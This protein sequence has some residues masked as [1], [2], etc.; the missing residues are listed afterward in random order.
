MTSCAIFSQQWRA[1]SIAAVT[2]ATRRRRQQHISRQPLT[3]PPG[4]RTVLR[5]S[6]QRS[7]TAVTCRHYCRPPKE[8][9]RRRRRRR[10]D[11]NT[12]RR[13]IPRMTMDTLRL[14]RL[15]SIP[16]RVYPPRKGRAL[17]TDRRWP[18]Q[19]SGSL[20]ASPSTV[21]SRRAIT[22]RRSLPGDPWPTAPRIRPHPP[23]RRPAAQRTQRNT[24]APR[25]GACLA[26]FDP[27]HSRQ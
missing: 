21:H 26:Q 15:R 3:P 5:R 1:L 16:C 12:I 19:W 11:T 23:T 14:R 2:G 27:Q 20:P 9:L 17:L 25:W 10:F 22:T 18:R 7:A 13:P 8:Q 4:L 6:R 24:K